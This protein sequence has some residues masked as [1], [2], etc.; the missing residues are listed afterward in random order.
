MRTDV[1]S[2]SPVFFINGQRIDVLQPLR[3]FTEIIDSA[4]HRAI[5]ESK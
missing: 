3:S 1:V 5:A 4:L 2:G